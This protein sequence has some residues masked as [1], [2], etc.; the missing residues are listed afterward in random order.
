MAFANSMQNPYFLKYSRFMVE[1]G[2]P[3]DDV[4]VVVTIILSVRKSI[5][6]EGVDKSPNCIKFL[7]LGLVERWRGGGRMRTRGD[8]L[9]AVPTTAV[10]IIS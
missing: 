5:G 3:G 2:H 9:I 6:K 1:G 7:A 10:D 8:A 4:V